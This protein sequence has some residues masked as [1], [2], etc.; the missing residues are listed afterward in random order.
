M[1]RLKI[2]K[3][4][5]AQF[6]KKDANNINIA[7]SQNEIIPV[8]LDLKKNNDAFIYEKANGLFIA[9]KGLL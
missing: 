5:S 3:K 7:I 8:I 4:G 6:D 2:D 9:K 1:S